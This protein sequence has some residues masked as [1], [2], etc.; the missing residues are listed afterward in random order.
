MFLEKLP[1]LSIESLE[2]LADALLDFHSTADFRAW[3][4]THDKP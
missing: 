3:L 1:E 4:E 2:N